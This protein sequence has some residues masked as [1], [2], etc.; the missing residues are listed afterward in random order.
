MLLENGLVL[1]CGNDKTDNVKVWHYKSS[2]LHVAFT[3]GEELRCM[4][5]IPDEGTLLLGTNSGSIL[6]HKIEDLIAFDDLE[7]IGMLEMDDLGD[8]TR[9][10]EYDPLDGMSL[11]HHIDLIRQK[12]QLTL[13]KATF[14][15]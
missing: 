4:D 12:E 2:N 7:D 13:G 5:Y 11:D 14:K 3:K 6:S 9:E 10:D 1:S 15:R 8:E